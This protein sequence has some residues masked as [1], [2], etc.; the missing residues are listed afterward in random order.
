MTM[1]LE[2]YRALGLD[3][4]RSREVNGHKPADFANYLQHPG[5]GPYNP[6]PEAFPGDD[7]CVTGA[8]RSQ[9]AFDNSQN[10]NRL[11]TP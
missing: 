6:C 11:A 9:A 7:V 8:I 1:D 4:T 10:V 3:Q 2:T 5:D